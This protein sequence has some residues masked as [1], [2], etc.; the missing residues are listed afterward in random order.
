[1]LVYGQLVKAQ[2]ENSSSDIASADGMMYFNTSI[3]FPKYYNGSSWKIFADT[4]SVQVF[5]NK[6]Y[7]G[8]TASNTNRI[9]VPRDVLANLNALTRKEGTIVYATDTNKLYSDDGSVLT[10]VGAGTASLSANIRASEGAGTT[11]FTAADDRIQ[12][13]DLSANRTAVLPSTGIAAGDIWEMNNPNP[14]ILTIQADDATNILKSWGAKAVLVA[15]IS[16]PVTFSDWAVLSHDVLY[17]RA[18]QTYTPSFASGAVVSSSTVG[19]DRPSIDIMHI[20]GFI[21]FG[22][23]SVGT[24]AF[25]VS[26]PLGLSFD[27]FHQGE[28]ANIGVCNLRF[29]G[30]MFLGFVTVTG[31]GTATDITFYTGYSASA[32]IIAGGNAAT[33][34][35]LEG[36]PNI[37]NSYLSFDAHIRITEWLES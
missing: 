36:Y 15:L 10:Q 23:G 26:F 5:T 37:I 9:T 18:L 30:F 1:M 35:M 4:S 32:D 19:W 29:N 16:T 27:P 31:V 24:N 34:L 22:A 14:Y 6:D 12:R 13:F 7:D 2:L 8:G 20:N 25:S 3:S 28:G 11:T 21:L 17:G 33:V